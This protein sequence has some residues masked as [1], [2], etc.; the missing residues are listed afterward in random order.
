[1]VSF[2]SS[3]IIKPV[4]SFGNII[5]GE[6]GFCERK[7]AAVLVYTPCIGIMTLPAQVAIRIDEIFEK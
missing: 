3:G 4:A 7:P 5:A 2:R 1:M 6:A